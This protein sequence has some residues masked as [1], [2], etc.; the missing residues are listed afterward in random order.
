MV[1]IIVSFQVLIITYTC[2][3]E[4]DQHSPGTRGAQTPTTAVEE[5]KG[6]SEDGEEGEQDVDDVDGETGGLEP[7]L[8]QLGGVHAGQVVGRAPRTR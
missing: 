2:A 1:G 5:E 8:A 4:V 7:A 6:N 3:G